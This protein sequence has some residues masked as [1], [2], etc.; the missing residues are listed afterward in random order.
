MVIAIFIK[1]VQVTRL[2]LYGLHVSLQEGVEG[3]QEVCS[4]SLD[5]VS[6]RLSQLLLSLPTLGQSA[7]CESMARES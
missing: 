3:I 4:G 7:A 2:N 1:F 6:V 5:E